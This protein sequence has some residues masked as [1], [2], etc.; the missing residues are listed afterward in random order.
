MN[1]FAIFFYK[2]LAKYSPKRTKVHHFKKNSRGSMAPNLLA[3]A[4]LRHANAPTFTKKIDP[5][6]RNE[7][8]DTPLLASIASTPH[9]R[10][11]FLMW[12]FPVSPYFVSMVAVRFSLILF[13]NLR[14][15]PVIPFIAWHRYIT[16]A[17]GL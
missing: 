5:P 7:I 8:L 9:W 11:L 15:S 1:V 2:I 3:N 10:I 14:N 13:T 4:W 12:I 6:P 16:L 17:A